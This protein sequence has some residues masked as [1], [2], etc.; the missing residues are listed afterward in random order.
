ML[1]PVDR[2]RRD[3]FDRTPRVASAL[4]L[5][6]AVLL[7][8]AP[9]HADVE[10]VRACVEANTPRISTV[11]KLDVRVEQGGELSVQ[12]G[13]TLYWRKLPDGEHRILLRFREPEDLAHAGI[14]IEGRPG[15]RPKVH[16]YLP[17][18][19]E[20][21]R[22]TSRS[23]LEGF[24]GRL[25]I[26]IEELELLL[27]PIGGDEVAV[28]PDP[29]DL[30]GR[31]VWA[32]EER[33]EGGD[34]ARFSRTLIL[35]DRERCIPLRAELYGEEDEPIRVLDV[36]V[37]SLERIVESWVPRRLVFRDPARGTE[38][39]IHVEDVEVDVPFSPALLSVASLPKLSR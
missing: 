4:A 5:L 11:Q 18:Q 26:G 39:V 6:A 13:L 37:G 33:T 14:L 35:V 9:A 34:D 16:M 32:L 10:S 17:G 3:S 15:S 24:L 38:T 22:V 29:P 21:R 20:P 7:T 1:L 28:L 31:A 19:G 8:T 12:A 30:D 36:D 27:D 25:H 23:Q 2:I